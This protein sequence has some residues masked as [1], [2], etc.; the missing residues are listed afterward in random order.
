MNLR[1]P[2]RRPALMLALAGVAALAAGGEAVPAAGLPSRAAAE[3]SFPRMDVIPAPP[4][5]FASG[6]DIDGDGDVDF[7]AVEPEEGGSRIEWWENFDGDGLDFGGRGDEHLFARSGAGAF[8]AVLADL[9]GD[10]DLDVAA[11][12][13]SDPAAGVPTSSALAIY[14]ND[15][16]GGF[17]EREDARYSLRDAIHLAAGDLD[18]DGRDDL[19]FL[20]GQRNQI[21]WWRADPAAPPDELGFEAPA[22]ALRG[23]AL[24]R[25]R[26]IELADLD[27]DGR[28]DLAVANPLDASSSRTGRVDWWLQ[29][30]DGDFG[31]AQPAGTIAQPQA[32]DLAIGDLD[33]DGRPDL[34]ALRRMPYQVFV[35]RGREGGGFEPLQTRPVAESQDPDGDRWTS[36]DAADVNGDG[37][38]DLIVAEP[39]PGRGRLCWYLNPIAGVAPTATSVATEPA[40][41]TGPAPSITPDR[42]PIASPTARPTASASPTA[43]ATST[44]GDAQEARVFLPLVRRAGAGGGLSSRGRAGP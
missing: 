24:D 31:G 30:E 18:G 26:R 37:R 5:K 40:T 35:S 38:I 12:R 15:G 14:R 36:L 32:I 43:R 20:N 3:V 16:A 13:S 6:G 2:P 42:T 27:G 25:A 19:V 1:P 21:E 34:A 44:P 39:V 4:V 41:A 9:D 17:P 22:V 23:T 28:L 8:A 33:G 29:G 11:L 10:G 7:L